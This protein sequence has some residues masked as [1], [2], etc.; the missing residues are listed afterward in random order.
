MSRALGLAERGRGQTSPNPMVGALVV[1]ADGT[2]VGLGYHRRAGE[3]HA[4]INA[5]AM[6]AGRVRGATLYCTL[7]PCAH[8]GRTG[9]CCVAVAESGVTRVVVA[10]KDPNPLVCGAGLAHLRAQ[11]IRVDEGIL[12][13][14]A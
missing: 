11:R 10:T 5:L 12:A 7:E 9:P 13:E 4:E 6:A 2:I 8:A 14:E 3:P 1:A